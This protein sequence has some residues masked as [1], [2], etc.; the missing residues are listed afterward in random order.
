M[1]LKYRSDIQS[2][3]GIAVI[4]VLLYHGFPA[5][6]KYGYLGVDSFFVI[7]GFVIAP[8]V[9]RIFQQAKANPDIGFA[10][11]LKDFYASRFYRLAPALFVAILVSLTLILVFGP[12]DQIKKSS[13]Q[14]V[15]TVILLG[16]YSAYRYGGNY[17]YSDAPFV[18]MWSLAVEQQ[19]YLVIPILIFMLI[20]GRMIN[21]TTRRVLFILSVI[22]IIS[23]VTNIFDY[24]NIFFS[25]NLVDKIQIWNFYAPYSRAWQFTI[26]FLGYFAS[27]QSTRKIQF[28]KSVQFFISALVLIVLFLFLCDSQIVNS[29]IVTLTTLTFIVTKSL[30]VLPNSFGKFS[31]WIGNRSYSIYLYHMPLVFL[32]KNSPFVYNLNDFK[33][34]FIVLSLLITVLLAS[35]SFTKVENRFRRNTSLIE[36]TL[37]VKVIS[38]LFLSVFLLSFFVYMFSAKS[39]SSQNIVPFA[40]EANKNCAEGKML[41]NKLCLIASNNSKK[42][43]MLFGDSFAGSISSAVIDASKKSQLDLVYTYEYGCQFSLAVQNSNFTKSVCR[44]TY[45]NLVTYIESN[46]PDS[47]IISYDWNSSLLSS[48]KTQ[49]SVLE[50]LLEVRKLVPKMLLVVNIPSF[51][52]E[53]SFM[54]QRTIFHGNH[55]PQKVFSELEISKQRSQFSVLLENWAKLHRIEIMNVADFICADNLCT[56]FEDSNWLY[57]DYKH[58]S[59]YGASKTIPYF[60]NYFLN[61][62]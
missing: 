62:K 2:L 22:T 18:H 3:R 50:S 4:F 57:S 36:N 56:R 23:F 20:G 45:L 6:F 39:F 40:G 43:V 47:V 41:G 44:S 33:E 27:S 60:E 16:N 19:I 48:I 46:K 15:L 61:L 55:T 58:L 26:G 21:F 54:R 1:S 25:E 49:Q 52:D 8:L 30:Y 53:N 17:F 37:K 59:I 28:K 42:T 13:V 14:S 10:R 32:A 38:F 9:T 7:S 34:I 35:V 24:K 29:S 31:T 5:T 11:L 51:P 12:I